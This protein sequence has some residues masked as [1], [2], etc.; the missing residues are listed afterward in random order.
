MT[1]TDARKAI[2]QEKNP[3]TLRAVSGGQDFY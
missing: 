2:M 1:V 3:E